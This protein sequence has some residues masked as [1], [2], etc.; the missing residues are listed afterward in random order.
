MALPFPEY[1]KDPSA[2]KPYGVDWTDW[3]IADDV[4][5]GSTWTVPPG[6][7]NA[8]ESLEGMLAVVWIS[9]GTTGQKYTITNRVTTRDGVIDERSLTIRIK[10]R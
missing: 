8:G 5:T 4:L 2:R 1:I 3:A 10:D 6:I 7:T 9:G